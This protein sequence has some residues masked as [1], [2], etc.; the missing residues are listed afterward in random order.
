MASAPAS[1]ATS[2]SR[3]A[4]PRL[5]SWFMPASAM[6]KTSL[7]C[8]TMLAR[9][10]VVELARLGQPAPDLMQ[11]V[12]DQEPFRCPDPDLD[13]VIERMAHLLERAD[14]GEEAREPG[15]AEPEERPRV[16]A[17]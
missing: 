12:A 4:F 1:A 10:E 14:R 13:V 15:G 2:A 9:Q 17:R 6:T 5:P 16:P 7:I 11:V 8:G 3:I